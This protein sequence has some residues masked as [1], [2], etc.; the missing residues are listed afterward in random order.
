MWKVVIALVLLGGIGTLMMILINYNQMS[1]QISVRPWETPMLQPAEG[2]VAIDADD[3]FL[4][5]REEA[6]ATLVSDIP[7]DEASILRGAKAYT[8]YCLP[9]HGQN[10]D[11]F[12]PVGPSL[13]GKMKPLDAPEVQALSDGELFWIIRNKVNAHPPIGTSMTVREIWDSINFLR[14]GQKITL[15]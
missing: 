3:R 14:S 15:P 13:P 8:G 6:A 1:E 5:T 2:A 9:C 12:G 11:G 7:S 10:L 4:L